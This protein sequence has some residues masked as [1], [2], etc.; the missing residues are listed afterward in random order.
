MVS[1]C[2]NGT[3]LDSEVMRNHIQRIRKGGRDAYGAVLT[4]RGAV[5]KSGG[6]DV[7]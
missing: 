7:A 6:E 5:M 2:E 1:A 4:R 3:A